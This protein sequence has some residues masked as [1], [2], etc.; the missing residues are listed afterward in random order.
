MV[1]ILREHNR[2]YP[3]AFYERHLQFLIAF[4]LIH[5]LDAYLSDALLSSRRKNRSIVFQNKQMGTVYAVGLMAQKWKC[6][7]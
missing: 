2:V 7:M 5:Q 4:I 1:A 3:L 6:R